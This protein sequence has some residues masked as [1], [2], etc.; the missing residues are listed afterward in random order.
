MSDT[1]LGRVK[2]P[3]T[4]MASLTRNAAVG[5]RVDALASC[6]FAAHATWDAAFAPAGSPKNWEYRTSFQR[7]N[8]TLTA[9][10]DAKT[11]EPTTF[12]LANS[13]LMLSEALLT[14]YVVPYSA[15]MI[16]RGGEEKKRIGCRSAERVCFLSPCKSVWRVAACSTID[17]SGIVSMEI[18]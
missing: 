9:K 8:G 1:R 2:D 10:V 6:V 5:A 16:L 12:S 13:E 11:M 14:M 7:P 3:K 15:A 17:L 18:Q 4:V